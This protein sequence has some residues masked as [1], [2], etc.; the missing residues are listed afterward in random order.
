M[1]K[2]QDGECYV[3]QTFSRLSFIEGDFSGVE[4]EDCT[5]EHC[6]FSGST[7][8]RGKFIDCTFKHCNL[9]LMKVPSTR[10]FGVEFIECK[11]VGVDWTK[12]DWPVFHLD[13][14]LRFKHCILNDASFFGLTLQGLRLDECKCH[15]MDFREGDFSNSF[16]T[17]CDFTNSVFMRTNLQSVDFTESE[18][19]NI[20]VLENKID[21]A[22]FSRFAALN[23]LFSLNIELVD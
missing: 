10:W 3:E 20:H 18:N 5:F 13:S 4:F 16:M 21:N 15:E 11:L 17:H 7:F 1:Q 23:L 9:S 19:F 8:A 12:A 22:T 2:I 6:D 14:E